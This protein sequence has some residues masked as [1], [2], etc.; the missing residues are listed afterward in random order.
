[1]C[2]TKKKRKEEKIKQSST[3][4]IQILALCRENPERKT[5]KTSISLPVAQTEPPAN[6]LFP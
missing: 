3:T 4:K 5:R 6:E 1:M 2:F